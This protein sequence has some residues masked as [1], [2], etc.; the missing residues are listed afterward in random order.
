MEKSARGKRIAL[1]LAIFAAAGLAQTALAQEFHSAWPQGV[2]R[3][4]VGP[5]Y[6]ANRLEDWRIRDGRL[7]CVANLARESYR[8]VHL[9]TR[10]LGEA[11]GELHMT[12]RAGVVGAPQGIPPG[13]AVGFL[14]GAGAADLDFRAAAL[15]HHSAGRGGGI[16]AGVDGRGRPYIAEFGKAPRP[17]ERG[18]AAA[19]LGDVLLRLDVLPAGGGRYRCVI[20]LLSP[21]GAKK[22]A[23]AEKEVAGAELVG[24]LALVSHPGAGAKTAQFWFRDWR[25]WGSKVEVHEE[26]LAGPIICAQYTLSKGTLK[27]TAQLM[28]IGPQDSQTVALQIKDSE[29]WKT[30]AQTKVVV[31]GYTAPFRIAGW[32]ATRDIPYRLVYRLRTA[33]GEKE[34]VWE[35]TVRREP[36]DKDPIVVAVF[37]GNNNCLVGMDMREPKWLTEKPGSGKFTRFNIWFPHNDLVAHVKAHKPDLLVFTGDQVYEG[38]SPTAPVHRQGTKTMLDYLYK[39]YLWC[40]AYGD[41]ARDIPTVCLPDDHDVYQGNLWGWAGRKAPGGNHN[42][43]GYIEDAEFV[44][45]VERTQTSHLPD[46]FDP[47]PVHQ[48]IGVYY[49]ALN[50]GGISFAI[51]E[52]RKFKSPPTLVPQTFPD[53]E[54]KDGH[55]MTVDFDTKKADIPGATLLGKRQL[56]FLREW[57]ADWSGGAEMKAVISQTI[58]CNLQTRDYYPNKLDRDL[59]SGGWPQTGRNNALREMRRCFA[60]HLAGDQHL[61]SVIHHGIE[62]WND[63]CWSFCVPSIAN[64]Y[65]RK[66]LPPNPGGNHRPG[67]PEYTGEYLDGLGNHITV[68]AVANPA[69]AGVEPA[70]LHD[71]APGYGIVKFHKARRK[72]TFECWPRYADPRDPKAKQYPGWPITVDQLD[73]YGRKPVGHLP[74]I[75]VL[76]MSNPVVQVINQRTGEVVYTLRIRGNSFAPKVFE[77]GLYTVRVGELGTARVKTLTNLHVVGAGAR[78]TIEVKL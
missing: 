58:F 30:I 36:V 60:V 45:M 37:T 62:E 77:R 69:P 72:I 7:E 43:G 1:V 14:I 11:E 59:D 23:Q 39:W 18:P 9:L 21:D 22:F 56:R 66:W 65:I 8:T 47:T 31:P 16:F 55:I 27:M 49:T 35:G 52:D 70:G 67:M 73:N 42:N 2:E 61:A 68:W 12:V 34:Y 19:T 44:K 38:R 4:W 48:G 46:P 29:A 33:E 40:W 5:E 6:W 24:N 25:V 15:V 63:A 64:F 28:P 78:K 50:Y 74:R 54:I 20:A 13:A 26:R 17:E 32:D 76:G 57:A 75:K 53:V 51:I 71:R 3:V 41:L 10:R